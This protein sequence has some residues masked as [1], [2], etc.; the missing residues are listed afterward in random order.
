MLLP[1]NNAQGNFSAIKANLFIVG[2]IL[3]IA[4]SILIQNKIINLE[5][6]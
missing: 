5:K 6:K 2:F 1:F 4:S 3:C